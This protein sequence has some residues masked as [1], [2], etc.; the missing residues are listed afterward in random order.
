MTAN[1]GTRSGIA[2]AR[3][4]TGRIG[5]ARRGGIRWPWCG[6]H[7]RT[8]SFARWSAVA[9]AVVLAGGASRAAAHQPWF[10]PDGSPD[11][12]RPVPLP[13]ALKTSQVVYGALPAERRVDY[14]AYGAG[15]GGLGRLPRRARHCGVRPF[16]PDADV[17][18]A[19]PSSGGRGAGRGF[20]THGCRG[21]RYADCERRR[22]ADVR[23]TGV[24]PLRPNRATPGAPPRRRRLPGR[25]FGP[26]A[27]T[28]TY[29]LTPDG[30][31]VVG[32]DV[33]SLAD[34]L[35]ARNRCEPALDPVGA[36]PTAASGG[37]PGL[38]APDRGGRR[39]KRRGRDRG[40]ARCR[41]RS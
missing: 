20:A 15:G 4:L 26:T 12:D 22:L 3:T 40:S 11:P 14:C 18:R 6:R 33:L 10:N 24:R 37:S 21:W 31:E 39:A 17:V 7:R 23:R 38:V 25:R 16:S 2:K 30:D 19:G 29:G 28:G 34:L 36:S 1:V 35:P 13:T 27:A 8:A 32:G 5:T 9:I 41:A